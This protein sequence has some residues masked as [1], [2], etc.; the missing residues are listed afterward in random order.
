MQNIEKQ[1]ATELAESLINLDAKVKKANEVLYGCKKKDPEDVFLEA[2]NGC[3]VK[4]E[5]D[6]SF[7]KYLKN[8][9]LLF[10]V[11]STGHIYGNAAMSKILYDEL[12]YDI[13]TAT[14]FLTKMIANHLGVIDRCG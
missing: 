4:K 6:S 14:K 1:V 10:E 3:I 2:L 5:K 9:N 11:S 7:A 8:D 12:G 13:V